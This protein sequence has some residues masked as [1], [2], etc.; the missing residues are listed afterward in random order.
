MLAPVLAVLQPTK[1]RQG[2]TGCKGHTVPLE[3]LDTVVAE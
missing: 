3:R 2:E 1:A